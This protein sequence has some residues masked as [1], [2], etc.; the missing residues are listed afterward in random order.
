MRKKYVSISSKIKV[1][2]RIRTQQTLAAEKKDT[3]KKPYKPYMAKKAIDSGTQGRKNK[4]LK[5]CINST[6]DRHQYTA[7]L[8]QMPDGQKS[9]L[10]VYE[11]ET[12]SVPFVPGEL[13]NDVDGKVVLLRYVP[14]EILYQLLVVVV[15]AEDGGL[16]EVP[17]ELHT[18]A[19]TQ[20]PGPWRREFVSLT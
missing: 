10:P 7:N 2:S 8:G 19:S 20:T 15:V 14:F 11:P 1:T 18:T 17:V 16:P 4:V 9:G 6:L 12:G 13:L 5:K 3:T